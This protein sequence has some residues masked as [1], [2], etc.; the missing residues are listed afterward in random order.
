[1]GWI[2]PALVSASLLLSG[3][4]IFPTLRH[5]LTAY[6]IHCL[7]TWQMWLLVWA[8]AVPLLVLLVGSHIRHAHREHCLIR[9]L[10]ELTATLAIWVVPYLSHPLFHLHHWYYG[11]LCGMHTNFNVWWSRCSMA[12]FWGIYIHGIA[13]WGRDPILSCAASLYQSRNGQCPFLSAENYTLETLST[14]VV[15]GTMGTPNCS[16]VIE[17]LP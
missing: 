1:V 13:V 9:K 4:T 14:F 16:A 3:A 11:W 8:G 7:W 17:Y 2:L 10:L 12:M 5:S 15:A 6:D